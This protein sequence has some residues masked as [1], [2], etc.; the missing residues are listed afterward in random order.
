MEVGVW[1]P[2]YGGWL[3]TKDHRYQP[4]F[5]TCY[6]VANRAEA[7]NYKYVYVSENYLN[8][9]YGPDYEVADAWAYSA[10]IAARTSK[11]GI[12]VATK[13]GFHPP[14]PMAKMAQGINH[15]SNRRLSINVVCGWWRQ[16]F[17]QCGVDYL[18][19]KSRYERATEFTQCIKQLCTGNYSNFEGKY[20]T[21]QDALLAMEKP[22]DGQIPIWISGQ[23]KNA[24]QLVVQYGDVFFIDSMPEEDLKEKIRQLRKLESNYGRKVQI[25]MSVF[26]IMDETDEKARLRYRKILQNRQQNLIDNFRKVMSESGA[27]MWEGLSDEQMVDS[28]CGFDASL[29]G[30]SATILKRLF[31]LKECGVDI[32]LCQFEDM[33]EDTVTFGETILPAMNST[34]DQENQ[35]SYRHVGMA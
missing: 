26:V 22:N 2:V 21:L 34:V 28:N 20:Y 8:V 3:R 15:L 16:E 12:V 24:Q 14:L 33:L 17:S 6:E 7:C 23:S 35:Q 31:K 9:V 11:I 29:I 32:L 13:P 10:A 27:T 5:T 25:A 18:D 30:S 4:S 19:H 1:L